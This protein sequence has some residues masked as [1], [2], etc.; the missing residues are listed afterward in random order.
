MIPVGDFAWYDQM[1]NMTAL[2]RASPARFSFTPPSFRIWL[3]LCRYDLLEALAEYLT[4]RMF[5]EWNG[6]RIVLEIEKP[7][8]LGELARVGVRV[9]RHAN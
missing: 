2:L 3:E 6:N 1:L 7:G 5:S 9:T 4:Q 8:A